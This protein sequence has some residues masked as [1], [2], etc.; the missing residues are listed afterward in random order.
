MHLS[1]W[2]IFLPLLSVSFWRNIKLFAANLYRK[3]LSIKFVCKQ[4][5]LSF[6]L[7]YIV[8]FDQKLF[9]KD[10]NKNVNIRMENNYSLHRILKKNRRIVGHNLIWTLPTSN[11]LWN[12]YEFVMPCFADVAFYEVCTLLNNKHITK[13]ILH[14]CPGFCWY[15]FL[16][17]LHNCLHF[18]DLWLTDW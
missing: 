16:G 1:K 6:T 18:L 11:Q 7:Y 9:I 10:D 13:H 2:I 17:Y 14:S 3:Q 15:Y 8:I 4:I 5:N 12:N